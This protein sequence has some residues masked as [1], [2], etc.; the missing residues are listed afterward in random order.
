[1]D[2]N[3][4]SISDVCITPSSSASECILMLAVCLESITAF[5]QKHEAWVDVHPEAE[6]LE[7]VKQGLEAV[8]VATAH[9]MSL[10]HEQ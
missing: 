1:M 10:P 4:K 6:K 5:V 8:K 9:H 2:N 3:P 7:V